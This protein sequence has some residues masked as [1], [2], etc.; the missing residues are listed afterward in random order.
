MSLC[1][2]TLIGGRLGGRYCEKIGNGAVE[3]SN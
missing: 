3:W 2:V 1:Q